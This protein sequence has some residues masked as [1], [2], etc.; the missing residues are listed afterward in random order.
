MQM[1]KCRARR[2]YTRGLK[3]KTL[4][5]T[6]RLRKAKKDAGP[7]EKPEVVKTHLRDTIIVP[8]MVGCVVGIHSGKTYNQ[9]EIKV[10][11]ATTNRRGS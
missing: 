7:L 2:R 9:V 4:A 6:K 11:L 1:F 5:F 8:E 10:K 3:R